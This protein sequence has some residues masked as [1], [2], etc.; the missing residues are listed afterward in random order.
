MGQRLTTESI[1]L[2]KKS[3]FDQTAPMTRCLL[4][5]TFLTWN[6]MENII[7]CNFPTIAD[8]MECAHFENT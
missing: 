2:K 6:S 5:K 3:P 4:A 8:E 1:D 7:I